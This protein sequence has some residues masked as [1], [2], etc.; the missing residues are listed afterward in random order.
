MA[1]NEKTGSVDSGGREKGRVHTHCRRCGT[2]CEKGGPALHRDDRVRIED[3]R[4]PAKYLFTI[5]KGEPVKDNVKG[6]LG[7]AQSDIIKIKHRT[8]WTGCVFYDA[9]T[10]GCRIYDDRPLECRV[11]KCWDTAA[12]ET[13]YAKNRLTRKDLLS[14]VT[15][16]WD[17]VQEHEA[18]C[19]YRKV[20]ALV[21]AAR[22]DNDT[23][24]VD[25][26]KYMIRYDQQ[27]RLLLLS[28]AP[29][30]SDLIL[31]LFGFPLKETVRRFGPVPGL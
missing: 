12:L 24:A 21:A 17:L 15:G 1:S 2:C 18:R 27:V 31:F 11:L 19:A 8:G 22:S 9:S 26:L 3:G 16:M 28:K 13:V 30:N 7:F 10:L 14:T 20:R 5:R 6:G 4:L 29:A 25:Q 23:R